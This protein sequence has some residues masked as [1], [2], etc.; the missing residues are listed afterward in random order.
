MK[1]R[2][3]FL[4]RLFLLC[5]CLFVA[6][7]ALAAGIAM[8]VIDVGQGD[9]IFVQFPNGSTMLVD[10]GP[11]DAGPTVV[12]YLKDLG[13]RKIDILVLTHP[14]SDHLG[15]M[16][17]VL[18]AF[19]IGKVWD[20]GYQHGSGLQRRFLE[21]V[22]KK[23][24]RFGR[25][26]AGFSERVGSAVVDILAPVREISGTKGDVN[27]NCLVLRISYGRF[28]ALLMADAEKEEREAVGT[29]PQSAVIKVSHHGSH[30]GTDAAFLRQVRPEEAVISCAAENDYGHPHKAT[31][32]A[33]ERAGVVWHSTAKAGPVVI[34][35]DGRV[36]FLKTGT[37]RPEP[38]RAPIPSP[39][40]GTGEGVI[41]NSRS[42]VFHL[43]TCE[44]LP[45]EKKQ[46]R[47][48]DRD[49]AIR[50]G[51]KPCGRCKP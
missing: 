33:L 38:K 13:V 50:A 41:G 39:A 36:L 40:A 45:D 23:K 26:K 32:Q 34:S 51:Y 1:P 19:E 37:Y 18:D 31:I 5:C 11:S 15:G 47:F 16:A 9:S 25:P 21:T 24:I 12:R 35:S 29:F 42:K 22:A 2:T 48:D 46:V 20:S 3:R 8:H 14:H 27:N 43:P 7:P 28:T 17:D 10:A 6:A 4:S 30:N 49:D 44:G